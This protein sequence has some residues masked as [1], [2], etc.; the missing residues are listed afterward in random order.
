MTITPTEP[1]ATDAARVD[2]V[3]AL[4][5]R[6]RHETT[7]CGDGT[8]VWRVWGDGPPVVLL[9][10]GYGS[11]THWLRNIEPL[12]R[13]HRVV[14]PDLPGLGDSA[15]PSAGTTPEQ[16]AGIVA[17]GVEALLA[18]GEPYALAGFSFG[19]LVSA[20]IAAAAGERLRSLTLVGSTAWGLP[21]AP[22]GG[23]LQRMSRSM[24]DEEIAAV[25]RANLGRLMLHDTA[26]IDD[27]TVR[28]HTANVTRARWRSIGFTPPDWLVQW[29]PRVAAPVAAI[30]GA[31]DVTVEP[32]EDRVAV[33]RRLK[34]DAETEIVPGAGHWVQYEAAERFNRF[35]EGR[36]AGRRVRR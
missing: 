21:R 7:P 4:D 27:F 10:G 26:A 1:S 25:Q 13:R 15:T 32:V 30:W 22:Q 17:A 24:S 34:P 35:L 6:A 19:A 16:V 31:F 11:W 12:S 2:P 29:L 33:L 5:R 20:P 18:P 36:L 28:L 23:G 3:A 9:H 8:M 14:V